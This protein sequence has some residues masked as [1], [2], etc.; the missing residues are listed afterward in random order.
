M[1]ESFFAPR[2]VAVIGASRESGKVGHDVLK[3]LIQ[4]GFEG[5]IYPV[6][7][8]AEEILGLPCFASIRDVP[9]GADLAVVVV[10]ARFTL[11]VIEDCAAM[12][13]PAIIIITAGFKE[14]GREGAEIER[15]IVACAKQ[16]GMRIVGPNCL[17]LI[18]T[19]SNL[20]ASFAAGMPEKGNIAFLSQSGAFGT[21]VLDWAIGKRIG[22]SKFISVGNKADVD[23]VSL[24]EAI[25]ADEDSTVVLGYV[26]SI[27]NGADFIRISSEVSRRK[28]V[29][30]L[31]SGGTA[32]GARAAS[33]HTGALAG[34]ED[35]YVAAFQQAGVL[36]ARK[37]EDLFDWGLAF[38]FQRGISGPNVAL[39]TNAGGPGIIATDA[40]ENSS[41]SMAG[42]SRQTV[43][44]LR[45]SLPPTANVYNPI[46]VLGDARPDRYEL[47]LRAAVND[48]NVDGVIIILTPQTSTQT[49]PTAEIIADLA[50]GTE[51]PVLA[52]FMGGAGTTDGFK[53][54]MERRVPTYRF[55]ERA[56][57]AM[58][59][60]HRQ[61]QRAKATPGEMAQFEVDKQKVEEVFRQARERGQFELGEQETRDVITAYGF[62]VPKS[63]LAT[64]AE[65]AV[66]FAQEIGFPVVMKISS[67]EILH[68]SDVGGV[69]VGLETEGQV[70]DAYLAMVQRVR[71]RMPNA[72]IR[73]AL[74]QEMARGGKEVI[75]GMTRDPQFGPMLMFGLG[76]IYVE[77]LKDVSFRIAPIT[78]KDAKQML[79]EIR[80]RTLL[81]GVRGEPPVDL[82]MIEEG[83]LRISQLVTDFPEIVELDVNPLLVFE[84]GRGGIA[85]DARL[86][87]APQPE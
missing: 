54:L 82:E 34:S 3:N 51:K 47:A 41:L 42:L 7:P 28:P 46:D 40:V 15:K 21:A 60:L 6:N 73:G 20:N 57:A 17:G 63:R 26:E 79:G 67:P 65:E 31:K 56:V 77:A 48:P 4:Y 14:V 16:S 62:R 78:R 85:I 24:I 1:L 9:G 25:G 33:S 81:H 58:D 38:S 52:C 23:E 83:L 55:P 76:G 19:Q 29:I 11:G 30:I 22:F 61:H 71:Q 43:N 36:R 12:K 49:V 27:Q 5:N 84:R 10:P 75:L 72:E 69:R 74:V 86:T 66:K 45:Q 8:K 50:A 80:A 37:V 13:V 32:A 64:Q 87:L 18:S 53:L 70:D 59:A 35:A 2:S 44:T 39:V 68:K